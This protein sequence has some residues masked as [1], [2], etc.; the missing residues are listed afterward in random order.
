[1]SEAVSGRAERTALVTGAA[2]GIGLATAELLA[3]SGVRVAM[4]HLSGDAR[5]LAEVERLRAAGLAVV[6]AP[7][8]VSDPKSADEMVAR[9]IS[10]LG[11]LDYL[12]NN[13]GTPATTEPIPMG[14]L[15]RLDEGFWN[16]ILST[17]L[18]GPFRCTR[19]AAA[20]LREAK[21][22]VVST[23]SIAAFDLPG[24]SLA[25]GASKAGLVNMTKNL[26]RGLAPHVRV[27][28]V[29]PGFVLSPWTSTWPP[30]RVAELSEKALLKRACRP[31]DIAETIV[32]L[33]TQGRMI[34]GQTI[35][36]DGGITLAG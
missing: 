30:A 5:G 23:A 18:V 28:A 9:A 3:R 4:N 11:R 35:I 19:A 1:M 33:L 14:E 26:A 15:D 20:A 32:F 10:D 7:G 22:A 36:V 27:N 29:A 21:G 24:S 2:S 25:Y 31:E 16:S 17:N 13:A 8:D 6:S 12:V 34:T